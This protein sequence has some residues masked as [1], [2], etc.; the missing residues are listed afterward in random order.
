MCKAR[1]R[2]GDYLWPFSLMAPLS[3]INH[4]IILAIIS[5]SMFLSVPPAPTQVQASIFFPQGYSTN[6]VLYSHH[7]FSQLSYANMILTL[8]SSKNSPLPSGWNPTSFACFTRLTRKGCDLAGPCLSLQPRFPHSHLVLCDP[9][10]IFFLLFLLM[11]PDLSYLQIFFPVLFL[12]PVKLLSSP[13]CL[14]IIFS[15]Y[16][17][18][19]SLHVSYLGKLFLTTV[20]VGLPSFNSPL[21]VSVGFTAFSLPTSPARL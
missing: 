18:G 7:P 19:V 13:L 8:L 4:K 14:V 3:W 6:P 2:L 5:K 1:T 21:I 16:F 12:Q 17:S 20:R 11:S 15:T 10:M 9:A